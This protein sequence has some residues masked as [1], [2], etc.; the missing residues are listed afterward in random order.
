VLKRVWDLFKE[1]E[2]EI[3]FPQR[4]IHIK[5]MPTAGGRILTEG[6]PVE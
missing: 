2:I 1:H 3:P 5:S 4:D 6:Q